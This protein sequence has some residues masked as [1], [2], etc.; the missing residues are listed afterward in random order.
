MIRALIFDCFGVLY[1]DNVA[2]LH[3]LVPAHKHQEMNDIIHACDHG[4]ISRQEYTE[5]IAEL[6]GRSVDEV[7][8]VERQQFSRNEPLFATVRTLKASYKIGLLS[9]VGDETMN[10]L[11]TEKEQAELF[12]TFVLSSNIGLIKP[13]QEIF[14]HAAR[15]LD[16]LPEECLMI[17]DRPENVEGARLAGLEAMLFT[18]NQR[19]EEERI[20]LSI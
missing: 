1:R 3:E 11:F 9:N 19:F 17:D 13:A 16:C 20:R 4:F 8:Q 14:L 10:R 18:T 15:E 7:H 2:L 12:D 5:K 6:A